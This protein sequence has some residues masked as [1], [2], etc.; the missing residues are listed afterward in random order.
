MYLSLFSC[1]LG[2]LVLGFVRVERGRASVKGRTGG[3]AGVWGK[4]GR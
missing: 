2:V 4:V 1:L 3:C